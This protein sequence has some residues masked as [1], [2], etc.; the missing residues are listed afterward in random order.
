MKLLVVE[1]RLVS[2]TLS[3]TDSVLTLQ[4][5]W[6]DTELF[7]SFLIFFPFS[8]LNHSCSCTAN[9]RPKNQIQ[10]QPFGLQVL[11]PS[12]YF[13]KTP[14]NTSSRI[15][16]LP[17]RTFITATAP[18]YRSFHFL[19]KVGLASGNNAAEAENEM[20]HPLVHQNC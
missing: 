15:A 11:L 13:G 19:S 14:R 5:Q 18:Q 2:T 16:I 10:T 1:H 7:T 6:H 3:P 20:Q 4:H 9:C 8:V 17:L 12:I